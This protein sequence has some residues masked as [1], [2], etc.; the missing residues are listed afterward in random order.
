MH[1]FNVQFAMVMLMTQQKGKKVRFAKSGKKERPIVLD[2]DD[3]SESSESIHHLE[4]PFDE[5]DELEDSDTNNLGNAED[6]TSVQ[7]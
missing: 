1:V 5:S 3:E 2:S 4:T 7:Y 6:D